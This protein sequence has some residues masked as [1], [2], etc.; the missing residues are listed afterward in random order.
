MAQDYF[1]KIYYYR[2]KPRKKLEGKKLS[3]QEGQKSSINWA[4]VN[5]S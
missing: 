2:E 5:E 3:F 4:V 1:G